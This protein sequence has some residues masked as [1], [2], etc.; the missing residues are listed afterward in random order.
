[1]TSNMGSHIIQETFEKYPKDTERAIDESRDEVLQLL[2]QT[3]TALSFWT[4]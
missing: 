4:V 2:K 3:G 1:M